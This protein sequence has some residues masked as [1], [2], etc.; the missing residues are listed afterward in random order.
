MVRSGGGRR[1]RALCVHGSVPQGSA[2]PLLRKPSPGAL[3]LPH[4]TSGSARDGRRDASVVHSELD[5]LFAVRD[6]GDDSLHRLSLVVAPAVAAVLAVLAVSLIW[7]AGAKGPAEPVR[8][9]H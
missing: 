3:M 6:E 4:R 8:R 2:G 7:L 5:L 9:L 1:R